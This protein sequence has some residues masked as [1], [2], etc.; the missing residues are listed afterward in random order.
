MKDLNN[1]ILG[2]N[3]QILISY[4]F[5]LRYDNFISELLLKYAKFLNEK[6]KQ[7]CGRLYI[8]EIILGNNFYSKVRRFER[9]FYNGTVIDCARIFFK[10]EFLEVEMFDEN[11]TG[12]EDWDLDKR[13]RKKGDILFHQFNRY[14]STKWNADLL[15][16]IKKIDQQFLN[17][18]FIYHNEKSMNFKKNLY[19]NPHI[20]KI[21]V[22]IYRNGQIMILIYVATRTSQIDYYFRKGELFKN[23]QNLHLFFH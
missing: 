9:L 1:E 6:K 21:L 8:P 17:N 12:P 3:N 23:I 5:R 18:T 20:Q 7:N 14:D 19:K 2:S 16:L 22:N 11:L 13:L 4:F 15:N 10:K